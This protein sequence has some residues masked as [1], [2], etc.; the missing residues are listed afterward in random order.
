MNHKSEA[1]T[2]LKNFYNYVYTQF[3]VKI[4]T[5]KSDNGVEF[6]MIEFYKEKG[7]IHQRTC[8]VLHNKML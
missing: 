2:I 5:I 1:R 3:S 7:I 8:L 4:K 6:N